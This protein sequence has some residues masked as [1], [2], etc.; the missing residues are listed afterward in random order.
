MD[1][2]RLL[3]DNN[4]PYT[5]E[6]KNIREGWIGLE[7]CPFC[8]SRGKYHLGYNLDEN[9]FSCW[10]CGGHS[11]PHAISR[12]LH[13]SY[14]YAEKLIED[15][16]GTPRFVEPRIRVGTNSFKYPSGPLEIQKQHIQYLE[17]RGFDWE[18]INGIWGIK[19]TGPVSKLDDGE[20]KVLNYSNRIL[21]PIRWRSQYV[22]FQT[23]DITDKHMAKYMACPPARERISHKHILYGDLFHAGGRG[24]I[25]EGITDVWRLGPDAFATFGVKFTREQILAIASLFKETAVVYDPEKQAQRQADQLVKELLMRGIPSWKVEIPTD[26]GAMNQDDAN[27]LVKTIMRKRKIY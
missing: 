3:D 5:T 2:A 1:I 13:I 18:Y 6:H 10:Q 20:G 21:A 11:T 9:Y 22:S 4:V 7:D 25:V 8:D 15:Y 27:H 23:R 24:I 14:D 17:G 16:G 26:P 19:G 12:L